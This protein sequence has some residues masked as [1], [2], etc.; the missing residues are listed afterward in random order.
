MVPTYQNDVVIPRADA[1]SAPSQPNA[2]GSPICR[3]EESARSISPGRSHFV[4]KTLPIALW[5]AIA[6]GAAAPWLSAED[7]SPATEIT[8]EVLQQT[9]ETPQTPPPAQTAPAQ[10][11]APAPVTGYTLSGAASFGYRFVSV[12]GS[13]AKY[14]ELFNLQEGFRLF[15]GQFD[16]TPKQPN[17]GW[18]DRLSFS[19]QGL[20][21]DPFPVLRADL[22][23]SGVYD[24]RLSY[25]ATQYFYDLPQTTLTPNRGWIDRRRFGD[26]DLRYTPTRNLRFHFFYH[27]TERAGDDLA[28]SPFFYLPL[29]L[30]FWQ[31]FGR[32]NS[33]SWVVPIREE[34]NL[35]GGGVDYRL[36]KTDFHVEQSYRTYNNP[37]NLEGFANQPI[38]LLGPGS[39]AQNIVIN[40]WDSFAGFNIPMTSIHIDQEVDE[41]LQLRAGYVDTHANGPTSLNGSVLVPGIVPGLPGIVNPSVPLNYTGA[42]TTNLTT[43][44]AEAGFTLKLFEQM[45]FISD[46]RYQ[47]FSERANESIQATRSDLVGPVSLSQD[48]LRWDFGIHTLDTVLTYTPWSDLSIRAGVRFLKEDIV[49]KT[50]GQTD[51]GTQ[52]SWY[53]TP[54]VNVAWT[55]SKKFSLRGDFESRTAVDPYVRISPESTVG[56]TI[57]TRFSPSDKWGIDNTWSF[58]N[59]KTQDIQFIAHSRTNSTTLW[60]Q[61]LDKLG[62]QGGFNYGNFSSQNTIGFLSGVPP[63]T[64]FFSTDQTIDRTFFYGIKINPKDSL[65]LA[66]TGQF[67]RSTGLG[68]FTGET[69]TYGPLSWPAW[70]AEVGYTTKHVGRMVASWQRSYYH[71]DLF[72][73]TDYSASG[74]TLRFERAF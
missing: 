59:L 22:R 45:D 48:S 57:R 21:G 35:F 70:S 18:F 72:R 26:A 20:G 3:P 43:Q 25:R 66:F 34:A 4:V 29:G 9:P 23:K 74:F 52:R 60:L 12:G 2:P 14:D 40:R 24:L 73:A 53:Y 68:T 15:D 10:Q 61:P 62:F 44:T 38:S 58:R 49:R 64:G 71:E 56:S 27:R 55:P 47:I 46:Y 50:N 63:L 51:I 69:S 6:A 54:L 41:R 32:A 28:T 39:P 37:A 42:G 19:A 31:A 5:L 16:L 36:G 8:T 7:S 30:D 1:L 11:P 65:T 17:T 67:I 33:L 13:R